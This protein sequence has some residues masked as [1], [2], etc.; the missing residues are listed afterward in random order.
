MS[1]LHIAVN[2]WFIDKPHAGSGQYLQALLETWKRQPA[3]PRVTLLTPAHLTPPRLAGVEIVA[4]PSRRGALG[5]V[6]WEQV[7]VP[8][9]ARHLAAD[10][11]W[12]PY[13]AAPWWQPVPTVVTVHDLIPLLLP[14]YRGGLQHRLYTALVGATAAHAAAILT[15]SHAAKRDIVAHLRV[16]PARVHVVHHGP[17]R[18]TADAP[19][20]A[21][22][23]AVRAAYGL[24]ERYFLYFGGFDVRKNVTSV[25][26][27]Y[28]RY[29][30]RGGDPT[31]GLVLA[32]K[33]P[34]ADSAFAPDPRRLAADAG[35]AESVHCC[36]FVAEEDKAS[37]FAG[38]VAFLFPSLYEGFGMPVVEAMAAGTPVIT[39]R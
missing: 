24:P 34:D 21:Q 25:I 11:L 5:K 9:A 17:A 2:G 35:V 16:D 13:W 38:A 15:V 6:W 18:D 14:A 39:A 30:D 19:D 7:S 27:A 22:R 37:L 26:A 1:A 12:V 23:A 3:G 32:G 4:L 29:L 28:R 8:R 33:L 36:G 31:V 10:V 20:A